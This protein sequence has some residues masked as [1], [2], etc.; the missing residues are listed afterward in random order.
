MEYTPTRVLA[1]K[2]AG[3]VSAILVGVHGN[4]RAGVEALEELNLHTIDAGEV[5]LIVGN[6]KA[7]AEGVRFIDTN[8]NRLFRPEEE[9][10]EEDKR[11]YEYERSREILH[12]IEGVDALLDIHGS[13]SPESEPFCICEAHAF[14]YAKTFPAHRIVSGFDALEPGG[15]DGY[16]NALGGMGMCFETGYINDPQGV[17]RAKE[18]IMA[19]LILRGHIAGVAPAQTPKIWVHMQSLYHTKTND[20]QPEK[21]FADFEEVQRG[22]CIGKDG[23][24]LVCAEDDGIVL[25]VRPR[26][27]VGDEA[28]LF[29]TQKGMM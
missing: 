8:L 15:S 14:A 13:N 9:I 25:F 3:N 11:T 22:A 2:Q 24:E 28:F 5:R 17:V 20:F 16:M 21:P 29:G 4:E 1:G 12:D 6:P 19:F 27:R 23:G 10:N 7:I 18:A 26:T